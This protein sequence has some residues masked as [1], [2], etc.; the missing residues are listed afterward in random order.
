[1][2]LV[3]AGLIALLVLV[4]PVLLIARLAGMAFPFGGW[5]WIAALP[6]IVLAVLLGGVGATIGARVGPLWQLIQFFWRQLPDARYGIV[7]GSS[8]KAGGLGALT[9]Y[10]SAQLDRIAATPPG[11]CLTIA[12]LAAKGI[13][14]K[15]VTTNVSHGRP[16]VL[17]FED[18]EF[19]IFKTSD[20]EQLFPRAVVVQM[21]RAGA[22]RDAEME[23]P[24]LTPRPLALPEGF[25][26][27]PR[28]ADLPVALVMRM[29]LSF[30]VLIAAVPL[31]TVK[32]SAYGRRAG[33]EVL[34]LTAD[35][36]QQNWFSDGGV[37]SNFPIHFFD[38]WLP[39]RPTFGINLT[40]R[41][42]E[43]FTPDRQALRPEFQSDIGAGEAEARANGGSAAPAAGREAVWLPK[44][45]EHRAA[46]PEWNEVAG[47][48][49]FIGG[50]FSAA[51]N[52]R[53]NL[54][55]GLPSYRERI[56][57][58][59]LLP[60]EG[61]MNLDMPKDVVAKI[62]QKG[63]TA[64]RKLLTEFGFEDHRWTRLLALMAEMEE[65]FARMPPRLKEVEGELDAWIA[66]ENK[67]PPSYRREQT[68]LIAA[69]SR[70]ALME[71]F[72][73]EW[74]GLASDGFEGFRARRPKPTPVLRATPKV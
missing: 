9:D 64:G 67:R 29:S 52:Y 42:E 31:Y 7:Q 48:P 53:D 11:E 14:L 55:A 20:L 38:A 35:D 13:E 54:Q 26:R 32:G 34:R 37:C 21:E 17:P 18:N 24:S 62:V 30:P 65:N 58:I 2:G 68:W 6:A 5:G 22:V 43:A 74:Q 1:V 61:G 50:I 57:R 16:Y 60:D 8:G 19:F 39:G 10:L 73:S 72:A 36:L 25:H 47:L 59:N 69:R 23:D 63:E 45:N 27:V 15:C 66:D 49:Q 70:V 40:Y 33:H 12:H 51:Q 3:L 44:A 41:S 28:S 46:N 71:K 4:V 56:V